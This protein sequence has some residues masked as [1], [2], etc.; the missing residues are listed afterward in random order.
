MRMASAPTGRRCHTVV[1][2]GTGPAAAITVRRESD[3]GADML[4]GIDVSEA[5]SALYVALLEVP[6]AP[7]SELG[8]MLGGRPWEQPLAELLERGLASELPGRPRR[9]AAAPP[10]LAIESLI[11]QREEELQR[12]RQEIH[13]LENRYRASRSGSPAHDVMEIVTTNADTLKRWEQVQWSARVQVRSFDRPP[14]V[15]DPLD[16][17]PLE[18]QLLAAGIAYRSVYQADGYSIPGRPEA[19][20]DLIGHGEQA[21]V[22]E[23][24]PVKMFIA[25]DQL[26][27]LPLEWSG[28]TESSVIIHASSLLDSLIMLFEQVWERAVPVHADGSLP[29]LGS[30][31]TTEEATLIGLLAAGLTDSSI[32]RQLGAHPRT[33]QRRVR[34]LLNRLDA[35]SRFQAG[36]QAGRRGWL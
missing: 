19:L 21:R 6:A 9:Y 13:N 26:G 10:H 11:R 17:N 33:V 2:V 34:A 12:T 4:D 31:P 8:S 32:A 15:S 7:R 3:K 35:S 27:I 20:R 23:R 25:D 16:G 24:V 22:V 5:A 36:L 28:A 14:Y 18:K 29:G 30:R 1:L